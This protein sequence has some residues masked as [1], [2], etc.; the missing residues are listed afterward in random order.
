MSTLLALLLPLSFS[1]QSPQDL[2]I[3]DTVYWDTLDD[4]GQLT[5]G[6]LRL[7][8]PDRRAITG[9]LPAP[10]ETL[11]QNLLPVDPDHRIDLVIVGDGYTSAQIPTYVTQA[12]SIGVQFFN[13]QPYTAYRNYF[14]VH[15]IDVVS[16]ESGVDNDPTLGVLKNTALDMA[17]W[18]SNIERL[19]CVSVSKA[20]QF[21]N[22][23][24]DAD[25]VL[26]IANSS[27]HGGAGYSSSDLATSAAGNS[28]ALEIVRHE[29]GHAL[30]NLADEYDYADGTTYT[31]SEPSA[32]NTSK[33]TS[34]NMLAQQMKWW[35]WLG[36]ND[37]A[38]DG[39]VSTFQ[40]AG[41]Y[42]FG[43]YRPTNNSIMRSLGRPFNLPGAERMILEIY[44]IVPPI[45]THSS[46]AATYSGT[47][48][49]SVTPMQPIGHSLT[50][51]WSLNGAPI[52]GATGTTLNLATLGLGACPATVSVIVQDPTTLVRDE[53]ART[54]WM[55]QSL[56]FQIVPSQPQF[57]TYCIAAPNSVGPGATMNWAGSASV[58]ANNLVLNAIGCPP[59]TSG[60][61]YYGQTSAQTPFGNGFRCVGGSVFRLPVLTTNSFGDAVQPVNLGTMPGGPIL[62]G[63]TWHFQLWYR[64]PAG[65][66]TGF[67]LSNGLRVRFCP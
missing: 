4:T 2:T 61:F 53:A 13:K 33:L 62:A 32:P 12:N 30:G 35:R 51:Q 15:R 48:T 59:G 60:L 47:E 28:S 5:G 23:A 44:K 7:R 66:G 24:P 41:Y 1:A 39:S 46:T 52:P 14:T 16:A 27:K 25:L 34:A 8:V 26:A 63:Q 3:E 37:P 56:S 22:N 58:S 31:G 10:H 57:E 65:G 55:T 54:Q 64:N 20:Y 18:C 42:Q 49:L 6:V 43:L 11:T 50:V 36:V 17:Y 40:G 38:W 29:F 45:D 9:V 19:L 21:A 67:N